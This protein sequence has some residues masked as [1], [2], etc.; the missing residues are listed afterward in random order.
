MRSNGAT[1]NDSHSLPKQSRRV[2]GAR[3]KVCGIGPP[4]ASPDKRSVLAKGDVPFT[5]TSALAPTAAGNA[6]FCL[7]DGRQEHHEG[8]HWRRECR[9][10]HAHENKSRQP[11]GLEPAPCCLNVG[12]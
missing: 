2:A 4:D 12:G 7:G 11:C 6:Q 3:K 9:Y 1:P 8:C 10:R 5:R